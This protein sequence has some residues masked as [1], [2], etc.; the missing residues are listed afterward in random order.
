MRSL[1]LDPGRPGLLTGTFARGLATLAV[2]ASATACSKPDQPAVSGN[3]AGGAMAGAASTDSMATHNMAGMGDS[4][5]KMGGMGVMAG[6]TG[7]AD[8][9]F[10][11]MMSDHHKGLVAMAHLSAEGDKKGSAGVQADA[12]KMDA[13]QDKEVD[14]MV[15]MLERDFKDAYAPKIMPDDQAVADQLKRQHGAAYNRM[16]YENV[17]KHHQR[18]LAMIDQSLPKMQRADLKAM[19]ERM[20]RDQTAEIAAFQRKASGG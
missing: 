6:M 4:T 5:N 12:K 2:M 3:S 15:T 19:A 7:N 8:Q 13:K 9:A 14:E 16:F 10:L 17:V 20:K 11:R 18:A 1:S